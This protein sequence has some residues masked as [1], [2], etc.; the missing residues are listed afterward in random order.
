M[1]ESAKRCTPRMAKTIKINISDK[2]YKWL[3]KIAKITDQNNIDILE[4]LVENEINH[5]R[6]TFFIPTLKD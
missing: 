2:N 6:T 3:D 1:S 4:K 5:A